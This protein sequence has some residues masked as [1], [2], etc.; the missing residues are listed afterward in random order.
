VTVRYEF[1]AQP[2]DVEGNPVTIG[3]SDRIRFIDAG[4]LGSPTIDVDG[5][6]ELLNNGVYII[7]WY[8]FGVLVEEAANG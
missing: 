7:G 6:P 5:Q 2:V 3:P 8:G 1:L 4:P